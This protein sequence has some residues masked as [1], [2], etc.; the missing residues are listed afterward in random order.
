MIGRWAGGRKVSGRA[1]SFFLPLCRPCLRY[2][3]PKSGWKRQGEANGKQQAQYISLMARKV[4]SLATIRPTALPTRMSCPPLPTSLHMQST[5]S[6]ALSVQFCGCRV[7]LSYHIRKKPPSQ[8][9]SLP[10]SCPDFDL[11]P[12]R[13]IYLHS[14]AAPSTPS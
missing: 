14:F 4:K 2:M 10:V 6:I 12:S 9:T 1:T 7:H 8:M 3:L 11:L 5:G 13:Y